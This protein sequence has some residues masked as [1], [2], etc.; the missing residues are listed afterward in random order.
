MR[1]FTATP[2]GCSA[3][4][5]NLGMEKKD[6]NIM[7]PAG[8]FECL[9]AAIQGGA[10]SVYFGVERLNMRSHSAN[11]FRTEDLHE[12]CGICREHGDY[13]IEPV[14]FIG[15]LGRDRIF[16]RVGPEWKDRYISP[17][18][19]PRPGKGNQGYHRQVRDKRAV[20]QAGGNRNV[21][22]RSPLHGHFREMLSQP[23]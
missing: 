5:N 13:D 1:C 20:R 7:A 9:H 3:G 2:T 22:A 6:I 21:R 4:R 10:D 11:N 12:I 17:R 18:T 8:N 19:Q 16:G 23:A 14:Y 15:I